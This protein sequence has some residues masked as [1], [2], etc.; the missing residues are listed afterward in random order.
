M[1]A[2]FHHNASRRGYC[3]VNEIGTKE[4]YEGKYGK[5]Y[6]VR[7]GRHNGST[8]YE[9]ISYYIFQAND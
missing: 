7:N 3:R 2:K 9:S 1:K 4:P 6:I 5:G 8:R